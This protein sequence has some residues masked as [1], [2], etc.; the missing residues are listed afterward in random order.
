M[1]RLLYVGLIAPGNRSTTAARTNLEDA[2]GVFECPPKGQL[3][4]KWSC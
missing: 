2:T 1:I 3:N 4:I